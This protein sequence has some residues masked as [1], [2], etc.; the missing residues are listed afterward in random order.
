MFARRFTIVC[1]L[2]TLFGM[3]F[4]ILVAEGRSARNWDQ[5]NSCRFGCPSHLRH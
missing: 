2:M 1:L 3:S 4:A 5:A